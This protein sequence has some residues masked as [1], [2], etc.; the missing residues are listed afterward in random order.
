MTGTRV[1]CKGPQEEFE[2]GRTFAV[3]PIETSIA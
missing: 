1:V 2:G 3:L